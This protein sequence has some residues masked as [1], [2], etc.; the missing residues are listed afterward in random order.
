MPGSIAAF[1]AVA[2]DKAG[3]C[4]FQRQAQQGS[5]QEQGRKRREIQRAL[6]EQRHHQDQNR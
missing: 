2:E 3:R 4:D 1:V 6:K 5:Q